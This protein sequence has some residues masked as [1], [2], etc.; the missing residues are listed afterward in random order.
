MAS[1]H[2]L[3]QCFLLLTALGPLHAAELVSGPMAG[4][5]ATPVQCYANSGPFAGR[6]QFD[7]TAEI[8]KGPGAFLFIHVLN[9]N[10]APVIRGLDTLTAEYQIFGFKSFIISLVADRTQGEEQLLR[11]NGSLRLRNPMVISLD[12]AEGPGNFALNRRCTLSLVLMNG[13]KVVESLAFTDAGIDD[14]PRIR[15]V[16][17]KTIGDIPTERAELMKLIK[18]GLPKDSQALRELAARQALELYRAYQ[19]KSREY[20][21]SRGGMTRANRN[22]RPANRN[23]GMR[24]SERPGSRGRPSSSAGEK[25]DPS[26]RVRRGNPPT[27]PTLNTLLRAFIR[28][29]NTD[30]RNDE[31]LADIKKRAEE[32]GSLQAEGIAMFQLMLSFPDRYGTA[33]AQGLARTYLKV[34]GEE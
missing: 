32:S 3:L 9:R 33:H 21:D 17:E 23:E 26:Q 7:A 14:L 1:K 10:T 11:V 4:T 27:D 25:E 15:G 12:G 2:D 31:I 18:S 16:I 20:A 6:E 24:P 34:R 22:R 30:T 8:G 28:S 19:Q 29:E 5:T 13:G